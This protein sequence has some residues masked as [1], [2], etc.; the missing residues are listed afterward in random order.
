[1][2]LCS[3]SES[4]LSNTFFG[5]ALREHNEL[6]LLG[7]YTPEFKAKVRVDGKKRG[8]AS[9]LPW[10]KRFFENSYGDKQ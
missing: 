4:A 3:V 10:K 2:L 6:T 9:R 7:T 5:A 1:M 8:V